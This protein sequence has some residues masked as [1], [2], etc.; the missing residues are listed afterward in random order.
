MLKPY[1]RSCDGVWKREEQCEFFTQP[2][3]GEMEVKWSVTR[4]QEIHGVFET[5]DTGDKCARITVSRVLLCFLFVSEKVR[6]SVQS[7]GI[8]M[9]HE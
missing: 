2:A 1:C 9:K 6:C 5:Q 8:E 7:R 4:A 3:Y